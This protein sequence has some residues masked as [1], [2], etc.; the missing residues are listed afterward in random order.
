MSESKPLTALPEWQA[1]EGHAARLRDVPLRRLFAED[2]GRAERFSLEAAGIFLDYS[3]HRV[4]AP[5]L[6]ALFALA[7]ARGLK[8]RV[9]AMFTGAPINATEGR[10]VLHVALR[11]A[12]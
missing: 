8:E 4:D 7:K 10:S 5:A 11:A 6:T 12:A 2:A 9:E 3:K 1:L